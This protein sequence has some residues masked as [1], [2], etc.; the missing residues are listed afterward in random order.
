MIDMRLVHLRPGV[1]SLGRLVVVLV[2][3]LATQFVEAVEVVEDVHAGDEGVGTEVELG[4]GSD[5]GFGV[6]AELADVGGSDDDGLDGVS[7]GVPGGVCVGAGAGAPDGWGVGV[8]EGAVR[9]AGDLWDVEAVE[10]WGWSFW[11]LML[12]EGL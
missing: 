7:Y 5:G 11:G 2:G 4:W 1:R 3:D 6:F 10:Y 8:P 12:A 9:C